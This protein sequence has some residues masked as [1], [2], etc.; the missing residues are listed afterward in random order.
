MGTTDNGLPFP[1]DF[2]FVTDGA[3]AIQA[4]AEAIRVL[5]GTVTV[6]INNSAAGQAIIPFP[7]GYFTAAPIVTLTVQQGGATYL[8]WLISANTAQAGIILRHYQNVVATV[9]MTVTW[10][11]IQLF[12]DPDALAA[13]PAPLPLLPAEPE[14]PAEEPS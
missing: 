8:P 3:A 12:A 14:E 13:S 10:H 6:P 11:A 5:A 2:A 7:A 9:Q 4:L 1:E